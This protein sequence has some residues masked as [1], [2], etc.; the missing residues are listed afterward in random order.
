M[1]D[2]ARKDTDHKWTMRH[3]QAANTNWPVHQHLR[4]YKQKLNPPLNLNN[5][6]DEEDGSSTS[7]GGKSPTPKQQ[8]KHT[9]NWWS[10]QY[11]EAADAVLSKEDA[12]PS[13]AEPLKAPLSF[14][15]Y[16]GEINEA[17]AGN[18]IQE[19]LEYKVPGHDGPMSPGQ[20]LQYIQALVDNQ[21]QRAANLL[22]KI[23]LDHFPHQLYET[24]D[25][26]AEGVQLE[27]TKGVDEYTKNL[28]WGLRAATTDHSL[29]MPPVSKKPSSPEPTVVTTISALQSMQETIHM[30]EEY[31]HETQHKLDNKPRRVF[32]AGAPTGPR[33]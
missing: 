1:H 7:S 9:Q 22:L 10:S 19:T 25:K 11:T 21:P 20:Y 27:L 12:F 16:T 14:N 2:T 4:D 3:R 32:R 17:Q 24:F 30:N 29:N 8:D 26:I 5:S 18:N 15:T 31:A 33:F 6:Q 23:N 13:V 28:I